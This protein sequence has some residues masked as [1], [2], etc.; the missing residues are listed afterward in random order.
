[1]AQVIT[2][3]GLV[4]SSKLEVK[5]IVFWEENSRVIATEWYLEGELVRRDVYV[6]L[7]RGLDIASEQATV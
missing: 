7:L 4:D 3:K 2:T 6:N 1:M 5:D